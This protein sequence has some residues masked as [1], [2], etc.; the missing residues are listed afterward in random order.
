M[1][2]ITQ[3]PRFSQQENWATNHTLLLMRRLYEF[4]LSKFRLFLEKLGDESADIAPHL[5]VVFGQ[6]SREKSSIPDGVF[7]QESVKVIVETKTGTSFDPDQ[8]RRHLDGLKKVEHGLLILLSPTVEQIPNDVELKPDDKPLLPTT[9]ANVIKCAQDC[10]AKHDEEMKSVV[11]DF[12]AF[13]S[14]EELLPRDDFMMMMVPCGDTYEVNKKCCLYYYPANRPHR[15]TGYLGIYKN[16][17]IRRIGE[18]KK[19][20]ECR[21]DLT[22]GRV[23]TDDLDTDDLEKYEGRILNAAQAAKNRGWDISHDR[24]FYICDKIVPTDFEKRSAGGIQGHRYLD[25]GPYFGDGGLPRVEEIA[26]RL[27]NESWGDSEPTQKWVLG[28]RWI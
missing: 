18:I 19:R 9:F 25:L 14:E 24:R 5:G 7:M 23:I 1:T 2:Q 10:L 27:R 16:K 12:E 4:N 22:A 15:N 28:L 21:V 26:D 11:D 3:F 6:Q 13:C 17:S 20:V 8:I